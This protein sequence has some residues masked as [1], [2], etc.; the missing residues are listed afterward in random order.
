MFIGHNELCGTHILHQVSG[1]VRVLAY[2]QE[3]VLKMRMVFTFSG[4]PEVIGSSILFT[5]KCIGFGPN[6]WRGDS[7]Y[8]ETGMCKLM[9][10][11]NKFPEFPNP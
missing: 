4:F 5:V 7:V 6:F 10:P 3:T 8:F 2:V 1:L 11:K 9:N